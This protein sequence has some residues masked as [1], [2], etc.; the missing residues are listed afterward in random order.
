MGVWKQVTIAGKTADYFEPARTPPAAGYVLFLHGHGLI[1]LKDNSIY[2]GLLE[3]AGLRCLCPHGKRSWWADVVCAE[4]DPVTTAEQHVCG[5]VR[6]WLAAQGP[7]ATTPVA[8]FGVSMGGQGALRIAYRHPQEFPIVAA[9]SPMIDYQAWYGRGLPL[10]D[11]YSSAE[12]VR[13]DTATLQIH[14]L[15]WPRHQLLVCDPQDE[16]FEGVERLAGKMSSTGIPFDAD[17]KTSQ[18]G[19]S[20]SYFN[21]MAPRV[22]KY[23]A[24]SLDAEQRRLPTLPAPAEPA[25]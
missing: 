3:E 16:W 9:V 8:L 21:H 2:S 4:F 5:E 24:E 18:G 1:T 20:W 19:H 25:H 14:P 17:F 13:Q 15:N 6:E 23:L 7:A 12:S 10:D 11:M 22:V